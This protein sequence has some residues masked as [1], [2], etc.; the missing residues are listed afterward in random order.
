MNA[1]E[2]LIAAVGAAGGVGGAIFAWVQAKA[3]VDSRKDALAA[4]HEAEAAQERAEN[5]RDEA[6]ELSRKAASAAERQA[7][8]QEEANKL[9]S[10]SHELNKRTAPP[11]WS[12]ARQ[13]G[14]AHVAFDNLSG[15]HVVITSIRVEPGEYGT[16][17]RAAERPHRV[18]NGD[19]FA[20]GWEQRYTMPDPRKLTIVWRYEDETE[21][22]ETERA[23]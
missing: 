13:L 18:E 3:A 15:R 22:S 4:Q 5:A 9:L 10:E 12:Q 7:A 20:V 16:L 14:E 23:L 11:A 19:A 17:M 1:G 21:T 6:L 2:I 8:A